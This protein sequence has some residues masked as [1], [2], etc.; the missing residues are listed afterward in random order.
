MGRGRGE[1]ALACYS[2]GSAYAEFME[3]EKGSLTKGKFADRVVLSE[4]RTK[5]FPDRI[6]DIQVLMTIAGGRVVF[7]R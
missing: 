6:R 4:G 3:N 2:M 1:E 7:E 5:T